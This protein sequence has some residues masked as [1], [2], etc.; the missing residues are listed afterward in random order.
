LNKNV[1]RRNNVSRNPQKHTHNRTPQRKIILSS[2]QQQLIVPPIRNPAPL[3]R[4]GHTTKK[5]ITMKKFIKFALAS[6]CLLGPF[7]ATPVLA[8]D[9]SAPPAAPAS[10][11]MTTPAMAGPLAANPAPY[12]VDLPDWFGDAGGKVYIGGALTGM[13]Y[14]QSNPTKLVPGDASSYMDL[15]NAQVF[16]QK[17]DGWLQFYVQGG[18]Y[19]F[20][21]I[22]APY[23][24]SSVTTPA[25]FGVVPVAYLKLQGEGD[26]SSWSLEGG[27]LPTLTGDEYNFSFENM[28]I[29][30]GLLWNIEPA[31]SRGVQLNYSNGPLNMS[32]SWNDGYYSNVLNTLSGMASYAFSSTDTLA[33]SASGDVAGYHFSPLNSGSIYDLIWTHTD[34]NWVISPYLQYSQTPS[35][36]KVTHGTDELG[37]ALLVSYSFSD[38]WK[39][40]TRFEYEDSTGHNIATA[41]NIIGY[42]AGSS[43]WDLTIT[44]TY[45]YKAFFIR[46][47]LSYIST[48]SGTKGDLFGTSGGVGDQTRA[49]L[50]TGVLF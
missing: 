42:G 3:S 8:Q 7:A 40:G 13:T 36:G 30:R 31:I 18:N 49:L 10:A 33:F 24:K 29:E 17:T 11:A 1:L 2:F 26:F 34:G 50:E 22:G 39:L 46:G 41:P 20:P 16:I 28:N 23:L 38:S 5:G 15:T 44:P 43:A 27:K 32:L 21:V 4:H 48:S 37:A 45:Q 6:S 9:N 14:Y 25:T 35:V 12:G 47:E 19:S